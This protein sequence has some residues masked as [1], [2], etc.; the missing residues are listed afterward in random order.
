MSAARSPESI[1]PGTSHAP[2]QEHSCHR[3]AVLLLLAAEC[4]RPDQPELWSQS[5]IGLWCLS[6]RED[7]EAA[8]PF[9]AGNLWRPPPGHTTTSSAPAGGEIFAALSP[10]PCSCCSHSA[11]PSPPSH[12]LPGSS[13][14]SVTTILAAAP[15]LAAPPGLPAHVELEPF[16]R[17]RPLRSA[18]SRPNRSSQDAP[19]PL[20]PVGPPRL[21]IGLSR[22]PPLLGATPT[23]VG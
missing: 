15:S 6:D 23:R 13:C 20:L 10:R 17:P 5:R 9:V 21:V 14:D 11:W 1:P 7:T 22:L 2:S 3:C 4:A 19:R 8:T 12:Q 16:S 18:E